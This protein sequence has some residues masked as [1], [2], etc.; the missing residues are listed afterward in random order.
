MRGRKVI[1]LLSIMMCMFLI[2][3]L[4]GSVSAE[5]S[6]VEM[7]GEPTYYC[8]HYDT[9]PSIYYYFI[10]VTFYNSG[11]EASKEIDFKIFEDEKQ[12]IAPEECQ[13]V[14]FTAGESKDFT[15]NW[16]TALAVKTI[17]IKWAP[18]SLNELETIYNSGSKNLTII[19]DSVKDTNDTPGFEIP[20]VVLALCILFYI[21]RFELKKYR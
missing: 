20:V 2:S 19:H 21:R 4:C 15:F 12:S 13:N 6:Y 18:S 1:L 9:S 3:V 5:Q 16:S 14:V 11:D 10:N 8:Y 17:E 7:E